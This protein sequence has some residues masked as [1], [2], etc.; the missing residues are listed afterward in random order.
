MTKLWFL[1][2]ISS[3][4]PSTKDFERETKRQRNQTKKKLLVRTHRFHILLHIF[5][6]W[7]RGLARSL[8]VA[9]QKSMIKSFCCGL[10][11][12][13]RGY[14]TEFTGD[15]KTPAKNRNEIVQRHPSSKR[16]NAAQTLFSCVLATH[17]T[18]QITSS[19]SSSTVCILML[20]WLLKSLDFWPTT[21]EQKYNPRLK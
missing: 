18:I 14:K 4:T 5:Y 6:S 17:Y 19:C 11:V 10:F 9:R 15:P 3:W 7:D 16:R 13:G 20:I 1:R 2:T 21:T 12:C 8:G